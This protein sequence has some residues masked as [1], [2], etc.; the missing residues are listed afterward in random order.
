VAISIAD[1]Q[2]PDEDRRIVTKGSVHW[3]NI[4]ILNVS[5][6]NNRVSKH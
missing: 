4:P 3:E 2:T 1:R 6:P 5:A